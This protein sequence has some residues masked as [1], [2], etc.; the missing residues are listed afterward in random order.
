MMFS[1]LLIFLIAVVYAA[2]LNPTTFKNDVVLDDNVWMVEF[3]SSMCGS[4]QEFA[5]T[6]QKLESMV[7]GVQTGKINIDQKEGMKLAEELGVLSEGIPNVRVFHNSGDSKG[8]S[9]YTG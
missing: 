8:F 1:I 6:W 9:I 2:D 3:Y 4:C 5:P 7:P